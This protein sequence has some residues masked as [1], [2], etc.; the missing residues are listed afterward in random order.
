MTKTISTILC[1]VCMAMTMLLSSCQSKI[2]QSQYRDQILGKWKCTYEKQISTKGTV[3][4]DYPNYIA[5]FS[6]GGKYKETHPAEVG[7]NV[8]EA[9]WSIDGTNLTL[10][11]EKLTDN[12]KIVNF[13]DK[14]LVVEY[15]TFVEVKG[16]KG[17]SGYVHCHT[18]Y[19]RVK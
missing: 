17:S 13:T 10:V 15:T 7:G 3:I 19:E 2:D 1:I 18:E 12:G 16:V 5:E 9:T 4:E 14:Q 8:N 11:F 6:S